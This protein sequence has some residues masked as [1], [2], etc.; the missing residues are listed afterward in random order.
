V[1]LR[2][3]ACSVA[4][5]VLACASPGGDLAPGT[6]GVWGYL[7]LDPHEGAAAHGAGGGGSYGDRRLA[8]SRLVDYSRPGFAV[9]Y[10]EG[11]RDPGD[12]LALTIR[13]SAVGPR[14][15]PERGVVTAGGRITV[16]N[17]S[18]RS[19][20]VS[21]PEAA[22]LTRVEPG[23]TV[24][25]TAGRAGEHAVFLLDGGGAASTVFAAPGPHVVVSESGRYELADLAPGR[26]RIRTWHPRF[27][28]TA[29]WVELESGRMERMDIQLGVEHREGAADVA[30]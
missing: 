28:P 30:H 10:A 9:V 15:D 2:A 7:S 29:H 24:E 19:Y 23:A 5:G 26:Q 12:E 11:Q 4:F 22:L 16:R 21:C 17:R 25:I 27:P 8:H 18:D 6:G 1:R 20:T 3:L 13:H 14:I